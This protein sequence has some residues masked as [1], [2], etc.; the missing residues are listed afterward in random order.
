M[1]TETMPAVHA[2][3]HLIVPVRGMTCATCAGRVERALSAVPGVRHAEVNLAL[4]TARVDGN[5]PAGRV[6]A[7]IAEAGY[8]M[9][10]ASVDLDIRGMTCAAC[11][12]RV[13]R[14]LKA[15]PGVLGADVNLA[16]ETAR[17]T[18]IDGAVETGD[19][20][21]AVAGAG[22]EAA[23]R[24]DARAAATGTSEG[25]EGAQERLALIASAAITLA[26]VAP[27]VARVFGL[28][29]H[30]APWVEATLAG[31]V[32][33]VIGARFYRN[34]WKALRAGTGNMD[35]LVALGT[36]AAY[37]YSLWL[38]AVGEAMPGH[39]YFEASATII[40][41]VLLGKWLEARAKRGTAAAVRALMAL[42]PDTARI[43]RNGETI[44]VPAVS[45]AVG[46]LVEV[47]PGERVPVDGTIEDGTSDLDEAMITG[48]SIAVEKGPGAH[49]I[50]G[51]V[52]GPG[53]LRVR[54]TAVGAA[55]TLA[56]IMRMVEG[57]QAAKAPV[58]RLVDRVAA[59]FVPTI[60]AIAALTFAAWM[61]AGGG[62]EQALVAAVS[63]L[64]IAC[65]CA[66]GLAT[67][68]ALV[69]GTG[70][71]ARA[72]IL[73]RDIE[74]LERAHRIDMVVFDK[75]GTLT[76]GRP[77]LTDLVTA[78][79][80][81]A[82]ELLRLAASAQRGSEHPIGRAVR[83][84]AAARGLA[85][86]DPIRF[87][88]VPGQGVV[89]AVDGRELA[90]GNQKLMHA[91]GIDTAAL[92]PEAARLAAN[93][94]TLVWVADTATRLPLGILAVKDAEKP[95][96]AAA[97]AALRRMGIET[98]L[99]TGDAAPVAASVARDLG[100]TEVRANVGPEEKANVV[101]QLKAGGRVVA[102]VGDGINDAPALAAADVGIAMATGT[103]VALETAGIALMRGDPR[104]VPD[105]L[106][107]ARATM[108]RIRGNLFWAFAYNIV[109]VPLAAAGYL[110]P[111]L[112]GAAM[113]FSSVSVVAN[114]LVLRRWRPK[115]A[116]GETAR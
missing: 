92:E 115:V 87:R 53:R 74:A 17:V 72:G 27:M 52:N 21:A 58:Q 45:V 108:W 78:P 10:A 30:P 105:A 4:E 42:R 12:G 31:I 24:A 66:L 67:P 114:A 96:S 39:L 88:A 25:R 59:V 61:L 37:L 110:S 65:P 51:T 89:A 44:E 107:V 8:S 22:Y 91:A 94:A 3:D 9:P 57:A 55:T 102:M 20:I 100:I 19:L 90:L 11:A 69:A 93:G 23:P 26:L 113:A 34:A 41:F 48:E 43:I 5:A 111:A 71:A 62:L 28:M 98:L 18:M 29:L 13:E 46:D 36:S 32:Q 15:V 16:L 85:E 56:R 80:V 101:S 99:L 109:G 63:V 95:E 112:A 86:T 83:D 103:D 14:A 54:A 1:R 77:V 84:A 97:V 76:Q 73:I 70:A 2:T 50:G 81:D 49:V 64:V 33:F 75:T 40:T 106:D 60:V 47:R 6:A 7:A 35:L 104:L 79:A 68:A 116:I 82:D 38:V